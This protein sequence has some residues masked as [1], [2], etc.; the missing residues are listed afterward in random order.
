[1]VPPEYQITSYELG[2]PSS[3]TGCLLFHGYTG[4]SLE[5]FPLAKICEKY[6]W[7]VKV[8]LL[9][10]HGKP[11]EYLIKT[12]YQEWLKYSEEEYASFSKNKER[13]IL[14]GHS[15][16]NV[17][18]YHLAVK[19]KKEQKIKSLIS[20]APPI[21]L[22][23][24]KL[25]PALNV[26]K[27][28]KKKIDYSLIRFKDERIYKEPLYKYIRET[29]KEYPLKILGELLKALKYGNQ[30][31]SNLTQDILVIFGREDD[32]VD[33]IS[34]YEVLMHSKSNFKSLVI[35]EGM[36]VPMLDID[37]KNLLKHLVS[38]LNSYSDQKLDSSIIF[39]VFDLLKEAAEKAGIDI[40]K[41][42]QYYV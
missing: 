16:G 37:H 26:I 18:I 2:D 31:V 28:V 38:W 24:E 7:H 1:M 17:L 36:H 19:F 23:N 5:M 21:V 41:I 10:G 20:I 32:V 29:Y 13:L 22:R 12:K 15:L 6:G 3:K 34:G 40:Q 27:L 35:V 9:P 14:F 25:L 8:G 11:I 33:P 4:S 30:L 39:D 42:N